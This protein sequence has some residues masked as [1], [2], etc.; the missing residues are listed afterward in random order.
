MIHNKLKNKKI[1]GFNQ[2]FRFGSSINH[3]ISLV[4]R[5]VLKFNRIQTSSL[6]CPRNQSGQAVVEYVLML[7]VTVSMV[8]AMK[9]AFSNISDFMYSY[10]GEYIACLMEYGELPTQGVSNSDLKNHKGGGGKVCDAKFGGFTFSGGIQSNGG[11]GSTSTGS[12]SG[13]SNSAN[14]KSSQSASSSS[15]S[16]ANKSDDDSNALSGSGRKGSSSPYSSG[17]ITRSNSK[18][19]FGTADGRS[20]SGDDKVKVIEEDEGSGSR[21]GR[22]GDL[23][24]RSSRITYQRD[25]YKAITGPQ[26]E[27]LR[28]RN[29]APKVPTAKVLAVIDEG[30]RLGPRKSTITPPE[31]KMTSFEEKNDDSFSFGNFMRWLIIAAMFIAIFLFFG[32]QVMN[33]M[34][35]KEK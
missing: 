10:V 19:G 28:R 4:V 18:S 26:E 24:T 1:F 32:S 12:S 14:G 20:Q 9:G 27:E 16:S 3:P 35:S 2:S 25:R 11:S 13:V 23:N 5:Q 29:K 30:G 22:D 8:L 17:Q 7:V 15:K 34:N 31:R 21:S 6:V 33:F